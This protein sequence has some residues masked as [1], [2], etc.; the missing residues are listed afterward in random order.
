MIRRLTTAALALTLAGVPQQCFPASA[1][2]SMDAAR[3][4]L[5]P[6]GPQLIHIDVNKA[7][8]QKAPLPEPFPG[9][10][11]VAVALSNSG[12]VLCATA[13]A[14][15]AWDHEKGKCVKVCDAPK[16][17]TIDDIAYRVSDGAVLL[18]VA[19]GDR[20][21]G[22]EIL[23][24]GVAKTDAIFCRRVNYLQ[25]IVF[26]ADTMC[27]GAN[28]DLWEGAIERETDDAGSKKA[29]P[30]AMKSWLAAYRVAPLATLETG[31][32]T[33]SQ[34]GAGQ[35]APA[36]SRMYVHIKRMGGSGWGHVVRLPKP[37]YSDSLA[38]DDFEG[39]LA[40]YR[41]ALA[42]VEILAPSGTQSF[43]C[44]SRGG[45]RVFY[46]ADENKYFIIEN[47]GP[48]SQINFKDAGPLTEP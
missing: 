5:A 24:K 16:D 19:R 29:P 27:F 44:A 7:E 10:D 48:P 20:A 11:I 9:Q 13:G 30:Q 2:F 32:G 41:K 31:L 22:L 1:V 37:A 17:A 15:W 42:N 46:R 8:W 33:P 4:Y 6:G 45:E 43:L 39:R 35:V 25:G 36:G 40:L 38:G 21:F 34:I 26:D 47:N 28:G 18:S 23:P 14:L 3:V 12:Y